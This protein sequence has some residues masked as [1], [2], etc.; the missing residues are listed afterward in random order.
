MHCVDCHF[1]QDA[2][3]TGKLYGDR[4]AAIEIQ[5][6]D[7]HGTAAARAT[8]V[9]S[10]PASQQRDLR[11]AAGSR[12]SACRSSRRSRACII[13]R[14]MVEEG[15]QW[16]V[17]QVIGAERQPQRRVARA[18]DSA[19]RRDVGRCRQSAEPGACRLAHDLLSLPHVVDDQSVSAAI[20]RPRSTPRS[21]CSTTRAPRRQ[22]YASY[23]PQMLRSDGYMLGIDGTMQGHKIAPVRSS[24]AVTLSVQNATRAWIVN[25]APTISAAGFTGNAFNT[26]VPHTVRGKETKQCTDCH[27]SAS[28]DNNAWLAS[29]MMLGIEPGERDGPLHLRGRRRRRRRRRLRSPN[30]TCR[31]RSTAAICIRS[32]IRRISRRIAPTGSG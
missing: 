9:T 12:R 21:R 10:G 14:S 5:C 17:P 28:G 22:V 16:T 32:P 27:V 18:H 23:N 13:Q 11:L 26:H 4:R 6:Q 19:R 15:K 1:P 8:L 25:Q 30:V 29:L 24:S 3:G 31:R 20:S 7:C 2:H